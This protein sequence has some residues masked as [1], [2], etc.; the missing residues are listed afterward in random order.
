MEAAA[1]QMSGMGVAAEPLR[2]LLR[3]L[4]PGVLVRA[5]VTAL[6]CSACFPVLILVLAWH[7]MGLKELGLIAGTPIIVALFGSYALFGLHFGFVIP[8]MRS[9]LEQVPDFERSL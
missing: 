4:R 7:S 9:L 3:G 6:L 2:C 8:V 1:M 5:F